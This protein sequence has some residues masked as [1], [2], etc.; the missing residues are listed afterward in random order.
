[1]FP[2]RSL[3]LFPFIYDERGLDSGRGPGLWS[4]FPL[5]P[6]KLPFIL[7]AKGIKEALYG[8]RSVF[9]VRQALMW[10][11]FRLS[12]PS[13]FCFWR[14][15]EAPQ[16]VWRFPSPQETL[17][18]WKRI[19][20]SPEQRPNFRRLFGFFFSPQSDSTCL[21]RKPRSSSSFTSIGDLIP[22]SQNTNF[23]LLRPVKHGSRWRVLP[24]QLFFFRPVL[25]P[26]YS[27]PSWQAK[28]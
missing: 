28:V 26:R 9:G 3:V 11:S 14:E 23:L 22:S 25:P 5:A 6:W 2:P 7:P 18:P 24:V 19:L 27:F 15:P 10:F 12:L 8:T 20:T 4:R 13:I 21:L 17:S 16:S 1:V